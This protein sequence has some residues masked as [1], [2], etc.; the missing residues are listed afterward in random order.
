MNRLRG[1][2]TYLAGPM[3]HDPTNG[4][5]WRQ[6]ITAFLQRF[7]VDVQD[8]TCKPFDIGIEDLEN[9]EAHARWRAEGEW[10]KLASAMKVIR[11]VDLRMEDTSD[12][13]IVYLPTGVNTCGTWEEIFT[14]NRSKRP[15]LI[16]CPKTLIP[17]WMFGVLPHRFFFDD[18]TAIEEYLTSVDAGEE[19]DPKRW[20]FPDYKRISANVIN[21][22]PRDNVIKTDPLRIISRAVP[23]P[24]YIAK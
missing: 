2:R 14:A 18:W 12:F 6:R 8:P 15:I 19:N 24:S 21:S 1:L 10:D 7:G 22:H 11:Q 17:G 4:V 9:K 20:L 3:E 16:Q 23:L 5:Q 13:I